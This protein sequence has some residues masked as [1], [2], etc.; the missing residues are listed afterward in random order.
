MLELAIEN[1]SINSSIFF[2]TPTSFI[3]CFYNYSRPPFRNLFDRNKDLIIHSI[4]HIPN[5]II[6]STQ[7]FKILLACSVSKNSKI[8]LIS[9]E[10][11]QG[12]G[13]NRK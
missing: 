5:N 8:D 1:S 11:Q 4:K 6:L 3:E 10:F 7:L 2:N 13:L 9:F 12:K